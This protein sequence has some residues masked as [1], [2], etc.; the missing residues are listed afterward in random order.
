MTHEESM[1]VWMRDIKDFKGGLLGFV[2][3]LLTVIATF[4]GTW[5]GITFFPSGSYPQIVL[6]IPGLGAGGITFLF[7]ALATLKASGRGES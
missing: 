7:S 4:V 3:I 6:A 1:K 2:V 5:L